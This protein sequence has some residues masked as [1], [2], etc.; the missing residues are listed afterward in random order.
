[1]SRRAGHPGFQHKIRSIYRNNTAEKSVM[2][3]GGI[4]GPHLCGPVFYS[5]GALMY[6]SQPDG[7]KHMSYS[8]CLER[9]LGRSPIKTG[10]GKRSTNKR[11]SAPVPCEALTFAFMKSINRQSGIR[12]SSYTESGNT[13]ERGLGRSPIRTGTGKRPRKQTNI[14]S[15]AMRST[16]FRLH[17][18]Q[19]NL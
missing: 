13:Y 5:M 3:T 17:G 2:K 12:H 4:S 19:L 9:G 7:L 8:S 11:T 18:V 16:N 6:G 14:R 1:M 15:R 10:T